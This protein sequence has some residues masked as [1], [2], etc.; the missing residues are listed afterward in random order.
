MY[1]GAIA[2]L[3][4]AVRPLMSHSYPLDGIEHTLII[5]TR[6][7]RRYEQLLVLVRDFVPYACI[8]GGQIPDMA[9]T[10]LMN[11]THANLQEKWF[12]GGNKYLEGVRA[13][14]ILFRHS[15]FFSGFGGQRWKR[16][17]TSRCTGDCSFPALNPIYGLCWPHGWPHHA[18]RLYGMPAS[19]ACASQAYMPTS[20]LQ[21]GTLRWKYSRF[22]RTI[23][24][25]SDKTIP[26]DCRALMPTLLRKV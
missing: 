24:W 8:S 1:W 23:C 3:W 4:P 19:G 18:Q 11:R 25:M 7:G 20:T 17:E 5:K 9:G 16:L 12:P 15:K 22:V 2:H 10:F 21:L 14:T 26:P 6:R 13:C